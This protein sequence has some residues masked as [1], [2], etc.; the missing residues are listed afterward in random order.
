MGIAGDP[1]IDEQI[2]ML[3]KNLYIITYTRG[4]TEI[5]PSYCTI[6]FLVAVIS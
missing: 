5:K 3:C 1:S 6:N 2:R 4:T